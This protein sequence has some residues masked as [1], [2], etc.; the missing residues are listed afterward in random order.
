[1]PAYALFGDPVAHSVSPAMQQAAFRAAGLT[2]SYHAVRVAPADLPE[3]IARLRAGEWQGAN[4]TIPHKQAVIPLLDALTETALQV[5]AVNTL[6]WA[7]SQLIGDNTDVGGFLADLDALSVD[8]RG[9]AAMVLGSGGSARAVAAGLLSRGVLVRLFSR[10]RPAAE[11][12][13]ETLTAHIGGTISVHDLTPLDI[14]QYADLSALVVNCTP[15]GMHPNIYSSPWPVVVPIPEPLFVY[16]LV[17]NPSETALMQHAT[18]SNARAASGLGMLVQQ[19]A[20]AFQRWAG[21]PA[22]AAAMR[23]AA[24]T[25]LKEHA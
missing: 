3:V 2:A 12:L 11:H 15:L 18:A 1:M 10:N 16:D 22:D 5:G 23:A 4:V 19:G 14:G 8:G 6:F 17:Y 24:Q 13:A 20:L 21:Q 9:Q 7:N 25:A